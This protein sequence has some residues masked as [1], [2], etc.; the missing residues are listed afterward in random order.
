MAEVIGELVVE[1]FRTHLSKT[2]VD[3]QIQ[4]ASK[5]LVPH[6][7]C[8]E[9]ISQNQGAGVL[10]RVMP[11]WR[12]GLSQCIRVRFGTHCPEWLVAAR[13]HLP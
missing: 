7:D 1:V 12:R 2:G 3:D 10:P 4:Q 5:E 13:Y 11:N 8:C 9:Q 6:H